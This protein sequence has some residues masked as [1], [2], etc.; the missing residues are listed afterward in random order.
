MADLLAD[1]HKLNPLPKIILLSNRPE[2]EEKM[3]AA[4]VDYFIAKNAPPDQLIPILN[5]MVT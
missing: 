4:G 1:I 3:L 5:H 2:E